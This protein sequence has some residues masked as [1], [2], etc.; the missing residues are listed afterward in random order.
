MLS[1]RFGEI[2][3][4]EGLE[5]DLKKNKVIKNGQYWYHCKEFFKNFPMVFIS[6]KS[7]I[8]CGRYCKITFTSEK[9]AP[10]FQVPLFLWVYIF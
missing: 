1:Q 3:K 2:D 10:Y 5:K 8:K 7:K 6:S 4:L 9:G